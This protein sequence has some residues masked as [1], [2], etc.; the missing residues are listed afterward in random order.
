[1]GLVYVGGDQI[2]AEGTIRNRYRS[3]LI[4]LACFI[5][6]VVIAVFIQWLL[7]RVLDEELTR[8]NQASL[9]TI[10]WWIFFI[11]TIE[12]CYWAAVSVNVVKYRQSIVVDS[13]PP[14]E[15]DVRKAAWLN[16]LLGAGRIY[17]GGWLNLFLFL[18]DLAIYPVL[19]IAYFLLLPL[20]QQWLER[21]S[22]AIPAWTLA[23]LYFVVAIVV[24]ES[25]LF[26]EGKRSAE[27]H[28]EAYF[29]I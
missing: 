27:H 26:R 7:Y 1:M 15:R 20:V 16:L 5:S 17:V 6:I 24:T 29:D 25:I 10:I 11:T 4:I 8:S 28:N 2:L 12:R 23:V 9:I 3:G 22:G 19:V 13:R 21:T 14:H 18:L